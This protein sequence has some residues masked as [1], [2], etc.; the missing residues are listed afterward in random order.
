MSSIS[1]V[2]NS[3]SA[4][5]A[6][7]P[8]VGKMS[9]KLFKRLDLDG[10][11]GIDEAEL[12]AALKQ[13][14]APE[15]DLAVLM[16]GLDKDGDKSV[17]KQELT[18]GMQALSDQFDANFNAARTQAA[19]GPA[20]AAAQGAA[21]GG[22]D[23]ITEDALAK[24]LQVVAGEGAA[25]AAGDRGEQPVAMTAQAGKASSGPPPASQVTY[26]KADA[27]EDGTVTETE[28]LAYEAEKAAKFGADAGA[29]DRIAQAYGSA[30]EPVAAGAIVSVSA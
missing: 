16:T 5:Q 8:D 2:S 12:S 14:G 6:S 9:D 17:S 4:W 1:S 27:N 20:A 23:D 10:G 22:T 7:R 18:A 15:A 29:A 25:P 26:D 13:A 24:S 19:A 3:A 21:A 30:S 11:G 28:R